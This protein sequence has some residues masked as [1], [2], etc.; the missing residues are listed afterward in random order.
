MRFDTR[1][2]HSKNPGLVKRLRPR[3]P[4][5]PASGLMPGT[6]KVVKEL[7]RHTFAGEKEKPGMNGEVV[8]PP[9]EG[10]ACEAPKSRRVSVPVMTLKGRPE[11]TSPMGTM[12]MPPRKCRAK[13][14]PLLGAAV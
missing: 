14:S 6:L 8:P 10:R 3:L 7:V 9:T 13:P 4:P 2:S 12:V 1:I 5:Q 11:E